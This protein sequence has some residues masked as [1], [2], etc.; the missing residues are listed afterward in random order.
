MSKKELKQKL[1]KDFRELCRRESVQW[2]EPNPGHFKH[3][4][5]NYYPSTCTYTIDGRKTGKCSPEIALK[6]ARRERAPLGL[7]LIDPEDPG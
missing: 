1:I 5:V 4:S 2:D 7:E 6:L 3:A